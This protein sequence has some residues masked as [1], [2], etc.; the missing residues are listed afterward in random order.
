MILIL[1]AISRT[2]AVP[3][4]R[5]GNLIVVEAQL[6]TL[7]GDFI[8]DTGAPGLIPQSNLFSGCQTY[9]R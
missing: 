8:L 6:D 9:C 5:A 4:K 3:I 7:V 2:M 1:M